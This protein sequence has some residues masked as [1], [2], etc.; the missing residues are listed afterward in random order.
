MPRKNPN[1]ISHFERIYPQFTEQYVYLKT[2]NSDDPKMSNKNLYS[3]A[4]DT[5][6]DESIS[7]LGSIADSGSVQT[8]ILLE[9]LKALIKINKAKEQLLLASLLGKD[10]KNSPGKTF[11]EY[12]NLKSI[13]P[14]ENLIAQH[15]N[16]T[17]DGKDFTKWTHSDVRNWEQTNKIV[18]NIINSL[19]NQS[20]LA[21][22]ITVKD[23]KIAIVDQK[24]LNQLIKDS[25]YQSYLDIFAREKINASKLSKKA[26]KSLESS[27]DNIVQASGLIP[28]GK[29]LKNILNLIGQYQDLATIKKNDAA[30]SILYNIAGSMRGYVLE[31]LAAVDLTQ[32][33]QSLI[34]AQGATGNIDDV[35]GTVKAKVSLPDVMNY[36]DLSEEYN[37]M[38]REGMIKQVNNDLTTVFELAVSSKD[39]R[40]EFLNS[41]EISVY[42]GKLP[43]F[44]ERID[45]GGILP[46]YL[47][48]A[49]IFILKNSADGAIGDN[50]F[51]DEILEGL[52]I[53]SAA[54]AFDDFAQEFVKPY[55][56]NKIYVFNVSGKYYSFAEI[57]E[58][59]LKDIENKS[60]EKSV[61]LKT[62]MS[63]G[64]AMEVYYKN[65]D[66]R[67]ETEYDSDGRALTFPHWDATTGDVADIVYITTFL[68]K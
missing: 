2:L 4:M 15:T 43:D 33:F 18:E 40:N 12:L 26:K 68:R 44:L 32:L 6:I 61:S 21:S 25:V 10:K 20:N 46:A 38:L 36:L 62:R 64:D 35:F 57:L 53:F 52:G 49:F 23:G 11:T 14:Q 17:K 24:I 5:Y 42:S 30:Q 9:K 27:V 59:M 55:Q 47:T 54:S 60:L 41:N 28:G 7:L 19:A 29:G 56:S 1:P 63:F 8:G 39:Y 48:E 66:L 50:G 22:I 13:L 65:K 51:I 58:Q 16:L 3:Q 31:G 67:S 37:N 45:A 34:T